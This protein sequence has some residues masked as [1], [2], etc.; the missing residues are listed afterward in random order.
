MLKRGAN[1]DLLGAQRSYFRKGAPVRARWTAGP[2]RPCLWSVELD[3]MSVLFISQCRVHV[4]RKLVFWTW[5]PNIFM[6]S[7][8]C[9]SSTLLFLYLLKETS[10]IQLYVTNQWI[11]LKWNEQEMNIYIHIKGLEWTCARVN[12]PAASAP[13]PGGINKVSGKNRE[14]GKK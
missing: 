4:L 8:F 12:I 14:M 1:L 9:F 10:S 5:S 13:P 11:C 2:V 7:N 3:T 6:N